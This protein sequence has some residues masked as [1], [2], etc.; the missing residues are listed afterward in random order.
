VFTANSLYLTET[1]TFEFGLRYTDYER[2]RRADLLYGGVTYIAEGS[3][4]AG[5]ELIDLG[6]AAAFPFYGIPDDEA[7]TEEDAVTGSLTLRWDTTD[8]ISLYTSY[9]RGYRPS[10]ISINPDPGILLFPNFPDDVSHDEET[11]DSIE[12]GFKSRLM[13]G[14]ASLNGAFYYHSY[15]GHL[16]FVRNMQL[17]NPDTGEVEATIP[18]GIIYNGDA[19]VYGVEFDGQMLLTE[20]WNFGGSFSYLQAEWDGAEAPCN[21]REPG[22][23]F[24]LCDVDGENIGGEPELS[25]SFNSEYYFPLE[26]TE[27][28]VRG[29]YKYTGERDNTDASAGLG[30]V[31]DEFEAHHMVNLFT[32]VRDAE[33][34][35]DVNLWVKNLL[36][37][38]E[39]T[40][41]RGPDKFDIRASGGSYTNQNVLPERSYGLTARYN[42]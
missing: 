32:G 29:L 11:S 40:W 15:D 12:L 25:F 41:Q 22:E 39:V 17:A 3:S 13:D 35:W 16:G 21:D 37:E 2:S 19:L 33:Y 34:K 27:V 18:G 20:T 42:F 23:V 10:G 30:E 26:S 6:A 4:E 5:V 7:T 14:R 9:N 1:V 38:D 31:T 24:G 28:Y 8:D 36:D